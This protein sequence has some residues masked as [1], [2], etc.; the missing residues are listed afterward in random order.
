MATAEALM[1]LGFQAEVAKKTGYDIVS[2]TTTASTQNSAG[3]LLK[4]SGNKIVLATAA[5][6]DGAVTLPSGAD[7][8]D[9]IEVFNVSSNSLDLFP[10]TGASLNQ[11]NANAGTPVAANV[12]ARAIRVTNTSW[13]VSLFTVIAAT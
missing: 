13:R 5:S 12:S 11:L 1:A 7:V 10:H 4:G 9:I 3:G 8:G 2:V 6:S